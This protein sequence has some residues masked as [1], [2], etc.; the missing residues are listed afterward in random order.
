MREPKLNSLTGCVSSYNWRF[1]LAFKLSLP[2]AAMS[3][4][5]A[6]QKG[7]KKWF[8]VLTSRQ[9]VLDQTA[10]AL[11]A[12]LFIHLHFQLAPVCVWYLIVGDRSV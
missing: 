11:D 8:P 5:A 2:L 9:E 6:D 12:L 7:L 4:D 10:K 3:A 1:Q